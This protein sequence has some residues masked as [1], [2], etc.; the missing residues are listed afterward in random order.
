MRHGSAFVVDASVAVKWF[1]PDEPDTEKALALLTLCGQGM[2]QLF[3][4]DQI[5]AEIASA[6]TVAALGRQARVSTTSAE[7]AL[8]D[9]LA[10]N[11][12]TTTS[13]D[14]AIA[15]IKVALRHGCALYDA[16]YLALAQQLGIPFITADWKLYGRIR[17]L[18]EV[19]WLADDAGGE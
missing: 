14:L 16:L 7:V 10:V 6:L 4:P 2:I 5:Y 17:H 3:T 8:S 13:R 19:I 12:Q 18:P 9:L 1:L 11:L 15:S